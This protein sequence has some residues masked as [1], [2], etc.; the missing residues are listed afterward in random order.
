MLLDTLAVPIAPGATTFV[1]TVPGDRRW[2][3]RTVIATCVRDAGGAPDR[4]YTLTVATSTGPVAIMP[5]DD[6]GTEPGA[7]T[8]TWCNAP[9]AAVTVAGLSVVVA[10]MALPSLQPGY[11][12][13]GEII[14]AVGADAWVSATVWYDYVLT[15]GAPR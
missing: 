2:V 11:T 7:E 15:G 1:A 5:A 4:S 3:I 9:A 12:V 10:P 14:G 13:T 6:L 8:I